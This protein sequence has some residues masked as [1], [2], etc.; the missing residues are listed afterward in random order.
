MLKKKD[1]DGNKEAPEDAMFLRFSL[2]AIL[3]ALAGAS[4]PGP[5]AA[6]TYPNRPITLVI[7]FAPGG[8]TSIVGRTVADKMSEILG[9]QIVVD[10]RGGAGGTVGTRAVAKSP[11][12]ATRSCSAIPARWRSAPRSTRMPATTRARILRRS[13]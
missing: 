6:Q 13:A 7:P 11:P 1:R 8:S 10:N 9:Q 5:A 3:A 4:A 12:T 2:A